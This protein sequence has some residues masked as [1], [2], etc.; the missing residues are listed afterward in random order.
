MS[1]FNIDGFVLDFFRNYQGVYLETGSSHPTDQNNTYRLEQHGWSGLLVEPRTDHNDDYKILR[2]K[3]I[4]ENYALVGKDF[5]GE[6]IK[7][8]KH[9]YQHMYNIPGIHQSDVQF[10]DNYTIWP[11]TT[12]DTLLKKHNMRNIDFF[13]LDVEGY[14]HEVLD[15]IDFDFVKFGVIVL[16]FHDYSWNNKTNDFSYLEDYGY[17][18]LGKLSNQ[19]EVWANKVLPVRDRPTYTSNL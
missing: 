17:T 1:Q 15:G 6:T 2:P 3:S 7:A 19:H 16:E 12:L 9:E 11:V 13:S 10:D 14:E 4:V 18:V 8:C 5:Q